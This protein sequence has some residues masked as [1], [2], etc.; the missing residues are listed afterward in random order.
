MPHKR[1]KRSYFTRFQFS[2]IYEYNTWILMAP[3]NPAEFDQLF[4]KNI[5]HILEKI[6]LSLDYKSFKRCHEVCK[7]WREIVENESFRRRSKALYHDEMVDD[8]FNATMAA[9]PKD[10]SWLLFIGAALYYNASLPIYIII[11]L[12]VL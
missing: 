8:L 10:I 4:N 1:C 12:S 11:C 5:P 3:K 2:L 6:F 9:N 7:A